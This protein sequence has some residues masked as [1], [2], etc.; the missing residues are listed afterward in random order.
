[1]KIN[2]YFPFVF[3]YFFVNSVALPFG[4]TYTALLAPFF[5]VWILVTRRKELLLPFITI[6]SPFVLI[7]VLFVGVDVNMYFT[8]LI[9]LLLVYIFCQAAYTF[10]KVCK[11]PERIFRQLL[12]INFVLCLAAIVIYF[13]PYYKILWIEQNLTQG[14]INFKRM[15]L[16][17]YEASYYATLFTP[18]FFFF[19]LQYLLRQNTI[20]NGW[21][22]LMI[23]LP[24][25][26]SFS[27][28]VIS[29]I[30]IA[31]FFTWIWHFSELTKKR[32]VLNSIVSTGAA[33]GA[34][35]TFVV[36][37]FR[38]NPLFIRIGNILS[39]NDLS[40]KGRTL[41][42]FILAERMLNEKDKYWGIGLGQVKILGED[43]IRNFY[44]YPP[45]YPVAI[46]NAMAETLAIFG[47][48]GF[49]LKL[50]LE[51]FLFFYTRVWNNYYRMM[52]FFFIFI[53]QFTGSFIT[54]I[55]E[56][57]IWILAFTNVFKQFD[58]QRKKR[59][60]LYLAGSGL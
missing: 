50:S 59:E 49:V 4:L 32:R 13:T 14:I 56:Y 25:V 7:Q 29:C 9:N 24:Y 54:N 1:M 47:W 18:I 26:L 19:L 36:L 48:T 15:K 39:G 41:D 3:I 37:F 33:A 2:K 30:I 28:G 52:L 44:Q 6:L 58:V 51:L 46:P 23:F 12:I 42:A 45:N 53:Y 20:R 27:L 17:T 38:H 22:L 40:G 43:I 16:F 57:V 21:L 11:D 35:M 10:F 55:A 5:Y 8:S 34:G 60:V 31:G